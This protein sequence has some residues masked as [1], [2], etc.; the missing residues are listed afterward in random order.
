MVEIVPIFRVFNHFLFEL[1]GLHA[2]VIVFKP[3]TGFLE[4]NDLVPESPGNSYKVFP[5]RAS[6]VVLVIGKLL[7]VGRQVLLQMF[8]MVPYRFPILLVHVLNPYPG[9]LR[10]IDYFLD[11]SPSRPLDFVDSFS[12]KGV[13]R[14]ISVLYA[15]QL[16]HG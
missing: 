1:A 14:I 16:G 12:C 3:Y 6:R 2:C 5:V 10:E 13:V 4:E 8:K 11:Q 9:S 15:Y 7:M